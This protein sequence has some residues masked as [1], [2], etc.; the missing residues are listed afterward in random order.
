MSSRSDR[1]QAPSDDRGRSAARSDHEQNDPGFLPG[2]H[3]HHCP[4]S[5][6]AWQRSPA[7]PSPGPN[8]SP[9]C[10]R[11]LDDHI[12]RRLGIALDGVALPLLAVLSIPHIGRRAGPHVAHRRDIFPLAPMMLTR[13]IA[14]VRP[15]RAPPL[16][17]HRSRLS[18][19]GRPDTRA[20][21]ATA[22]RTRGYRQAGRT[23]AVGE[24][25]E[26]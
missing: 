11:P 13:D 19:T 3:A 10:R 26:R 4:R 18:T 22:G 5:G 8:P 7:A 23:S 9:P 16:D 25:R 24:R 1:H 15:S 12:S 20:P 17:F 21:R 2:S 14:W 6:P